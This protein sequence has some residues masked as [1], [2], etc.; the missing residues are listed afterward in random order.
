MGHVF[1]FLPAAA[2]HGAAKAVCK[3]WCEADF[4][5]RRSLKVRN[6][7][8]VTPQYVVHKFRN[9]RAAEVKG[10]PHFADIER[11][12][13]DWG[14][15]AAHWVAAAAPRDANKGWPHLEELSFKRMVV[16]D[17]CLHT[18]ASCFPNLKVLRMNKCDGFSTTGL[19]AIA[20]AC[21]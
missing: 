20:Q 4:G 7:Y 8:A 3:T 21:G 16:T 15:D 17:D 19:E 2:D 10:K 6:C 13:E 12:P 5:F 1:S 9:V 18:I 14:A 11:L